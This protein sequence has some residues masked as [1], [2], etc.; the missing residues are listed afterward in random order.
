MF[1]FK[2]VFDLNTLPNNIR[3][4][5]PC[6]VMALYLGELCFTCPSY[7]TLKIQTFPPY[8]TQ[9]KGANLVHM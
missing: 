7:F 9:R 4:I 1:Q 2:V 6:A 3:E 5:G 8:Q